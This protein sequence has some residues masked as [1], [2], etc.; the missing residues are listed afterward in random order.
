MEEKIFYV[1]CYYDHRYDP[2]LPIY[3]GR[4]KNNRYL[5]H[6]TKTHNIILHNKLNA[7]KSET[8]KDAKVIKLVENLTNDE[9]NAVEIEYIK[10]FGRL[11]LKTGTLCNLT[12]G[13]KTTTGWVPSEETKKL[14]SQQRKGKP[15]TEAQYAANCNRKLSDEQRK[16]KTEILK[17]YGTKYETGYK[18]SK[19]I[20]DK[21]VSTKTKN[22]ESFIGKTFY[23]LTVIN[24]IY[25]TNRQTLICRCKCGN[26]R[27]VKACDLLRSDKRAVKACTTCV[28]LY[29]Y[30]I[31][32]CSNGKIY[33]TPKKAANDTN[34][35]YTTLQNKLKNNKQAF[36]RNLTFTIIEY[37]NALEKGYLP[38]S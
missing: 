28:N 13:G 37:E 30:S 26:E 11:D 16:I 19:E 25:N 38:I 3:V 22:R 35:P 12:D 7:I 23:Y 10:K 31:I 17:K 4:G 18:Q 8:G 34:I 6:Y 15:Q 27:I 14:W 2:A 24:E 29:N 33:E 1:Y 32:L 9:A 20:T 21:V 36:I 5:Q